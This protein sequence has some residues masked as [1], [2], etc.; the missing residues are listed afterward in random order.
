MTLQPITIWRRLT[1]IAFFVVTGQ[2]LAIGWLR[3]PFGVPFYSC[4]SCSLTDCPG[5]YLQ[6]FFIGLIAVSGLVF[7]RAFCGWACPMGLLE[8]ALGRLPKPRWSKGLRFAKVDRILKWLKYA[9][10]VAVIVL[11]ARLNYTPHRPYEY[12]VR[13]PSVFNLGAIG[14]AW[15]MEGGTYKATAIIFAV[16]LVGA[17]VVSRF[18]CRYLC[19]LGALL[20][21]FN[22]FSIV[23]LRRDLSSCTNCGRYP[24]DCVH[25]TVPGTPDCVI[26]GECVQ[27]CPEG[28]IAVRGRIGRRPAQEGVA[29][30]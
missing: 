14:V 26:C 27:G 30:G 22:W 6:P 2:W 23:V 11:I 5:R 21:V 4:M 9:A 3:C 18:W 10:L 16:A 8:E 12:V 13:S 1:Q 25:Y 17:L 20:S 7:G 28:A 19:P 29:S 15:Q 24:R